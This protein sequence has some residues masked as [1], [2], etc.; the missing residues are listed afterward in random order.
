MGGYLFEFRLGLRHRAGMESNASGMS[1][2][3]DS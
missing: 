3:C 2:G 1:K